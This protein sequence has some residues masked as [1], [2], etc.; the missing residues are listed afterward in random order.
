MTMSGM[1][2]EYPSGFAGA[3]PAIGARVLSADGDE[4]GTVKEVVGIAFKVDAAMQPDYWLRADC[5][6]SKT[7]NAVRLNIIKDRLGDA[8]VDAPDNSG[9]RR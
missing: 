2:G 3:A 7:A 5:I 8:K 1:S 4:L 6:S 9:V